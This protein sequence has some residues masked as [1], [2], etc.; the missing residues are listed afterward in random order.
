MS[1]DPPESQEP[2]SQ[3]PDGSSGGSIWGGVGIGCGSY[4]FVLLIGFVLLGSGVYF[5]GNVFLLLLFS[6]LAIGILLAVL[7]RTRRLGIGALILTAAAWLIL[8][9]PCFAMIGGIL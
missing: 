5:S 9:G 8:I 1:I 3:L 6:P 4:V 7:P 2:D